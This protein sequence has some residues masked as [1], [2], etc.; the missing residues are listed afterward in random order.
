MYPE[1]EYWSQ[2]AIGAADLSTVPKPVY[3]LP[4]RPHQ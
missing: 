3:G 2:L 4:L 1:W